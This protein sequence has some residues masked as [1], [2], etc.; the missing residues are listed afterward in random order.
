MHIDGSDLCI[1][2]AVGI[3]LPTRVLAVWRRSKVKVNRLLG[4]ERPPGVPHGSI[5]PFPYEIVEMILAHHTRDL[6]T[7]KAC[8]LTCRSWYIV[9]VRYLHHTL[10]LRWNGPGIDRGGLKPLFELRGLGLAPF[11]KEIRVKQTV[12]WDGGPWFVPQT[13]RRRDL[14]NLSAF[15]N[16]H[17][18]R[19]Q[20]LEI[21]RFIP[22]IEYYFGH[23][24]QTVRSI[25]LH[26]PRCTP[27]Q[28]SHFLSFFPNLDDIE[29]WWIITEV[30][31][32]TAPDTEPVP[33]SPPKLQG[34][35]TLCGFRWVETW[36]Q[37]IASCGGLRFRYMHLRDVAGCAPVLLEACAKT[38]ET[39]RFNAT[40]SGTTG[41]WFSIGLSI[42][43]GFEL[44]INRSPFSLAPWIWSFAS[45]S[46]QISTS[47]G[48]GSRS[49]LTGPPSQHRP[50][51][52]LNHH[53]SCV[54][55]ARY[56]LG[57]PRDELF[58]RGCYAFRDAA[59]DERNQAVQ[60]GVFARGFGIFARGGAA[61]VG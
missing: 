47:R 31:N 15:T 43:S 33:F 18:L 54:L 58:A 24:S 45:Q 60:I 5:R 6:V 37:L 46:P 41:K 61:G 53:I 51:V 39:L 13:F 49:P 38:L 11:I 14:R 12:L 42:I 2:H 26:G 1:A 28:L 21:Y 52:L 10:I 23:L 7:L 25:A 32:A 36:T 55:R 57:R 44:M 59:H 16:V 29:I 56:C 22:G 9:T 50:G 17:T 27:Q 30:P 4:N 20:G 35:L 3:N 8:S 34:Q 48:L 40:D 19:F